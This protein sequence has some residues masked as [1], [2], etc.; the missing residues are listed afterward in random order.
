M[1]SNYY[2]VGALYEVDEK[3][4]FKCRLRVAMIHL[5]NENHHYALELNEHYLDVR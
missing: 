1:L 3:D 2:D 4:L 5:V